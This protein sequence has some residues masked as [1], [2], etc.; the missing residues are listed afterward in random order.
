MPIGR[1]ARRKALRWLQRVM[2][3]FFDQWRQGQSGG[4]DE[5]FRIREIAAIQVPTPGK[6]PGHKRG[7]KHNPYRCGKPWDEAGPRAYKSKAET[8][9]DFLSK[10]MAPAGFKFIKI[11]GWGGLGICSLYEV[12]DGDGNK[13]KVV[14]KMDLNP[15]QKYIHREI[16]SHV[17]TAGAKHIVQRAILQRHHTQIEQVTKQLRAFDP[18]DPG[19][20]Q[21]KAVNAPEGFELIEEPEDEE[22]EVVDQKFVELDIKKDLKEGLDADD[23]MLFI[24]FMSRG[25]FDD[26]IRRVAEQLSE[27]P[28]QVLWQIFD[29]LFRAVIGMAYPTAFHPLNTDPRTEHVPTISETCRGLPVLDSTS[30]RDRIIHFDLEPLNILVGNFDQD[31]HNVVPL[32]KVSDLGLAKTFN[33]KETNAWAVWATRQSGKHHIFAP[34]Q[35]TEEW[36][37]LDELP[38]MNISETAGNYNWW[39]NLYQVAL[40][41]WKLITLHDYEYPPV[42]EEIEIKQIDGTLV[43][44]W[45]YGGYLFHSKFNHIDSDLR[46][47]VALCMIHN[48]THRPKMQDIELCIQKHLDKET[49]ANDQM[50]RLFVDDFF[51]GPPPPTRV[52]DPVDPKE[53]EKLKGWRIEPMKNET[54][55]KKKISSIMKLASKFAG[56]GF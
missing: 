34:E 24:E 6:W 11:L 15:R 13:I 12:D 28:D 44:E 31:E 5:K 3:D 7:Q 53:Y 33:G 20:T 36:D 18:P 29:C 40:V 19:K 52:P 46:N 1:A 17:A 4:Y 23:R 32:I 9:A 30:H 51:G 8:V 22:F 48:P 38:D 2:K 16:A 45:T 26:Y 37:Y 27:F 21:A 43:K 25:R 49:T 42:I 54:L 47:L 41:M 35:H 56:W 14:C 10:K 55:E 50:V 39:T